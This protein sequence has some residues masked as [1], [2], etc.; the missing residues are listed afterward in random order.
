VNTRPQTSVTFAL[1]ILVLLG[2]G[3]L[4]VP[5][6]PDA[7]KIPSV[8]VYGDV[9]LGVVSLVAAYGLLKLTRW[10]RILTLIVAALNV[11]SAAPGVVSA[12]NQELRVV[13]AV[14]VVLSLVIIALVAWPSARKP[15][16]RRAPAAQE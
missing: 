12:P 7:D 4:F 8:V 10:G 2:V 6:A 16:A 13:T 3:H 1:I 9:A 11:L 15:S 14:Y 5:L